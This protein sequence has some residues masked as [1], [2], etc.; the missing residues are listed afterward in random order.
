MHKGGGSREI[1]KSSMV[2][3]PV[4]PVYRVCC[5]KLAATLKGFGFN[6]FTTPFFAFSSFFL[7]PVF[8]DFLRSPFLKPLLNA[9]APLNIDF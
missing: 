6:A 5:C 1:I 4:L 7:H 9:A 3:R 8:M 2:L